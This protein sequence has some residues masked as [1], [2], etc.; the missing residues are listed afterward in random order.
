M[1][2]KKEDKKQ[3][4][5]EDKK[6]EKPKLSKKEIEKKQER[7]ATIVIGI[8]VFII[9]AAIG[10]YAGL[11]MSNHFTYNGL[12]FQKT[13]YGEILLYSV[14]IPVASSSGQIL[15]HTH[16][17][18]RNDPRKLDDIEV[19]IDGKMVF[20]RK[21]YISVEEPIDCEY[22][23]VALGNLALFFHNT[24]AEIIWG[25]FTEEFAE[26]EELPHITCDNASTNTVIL[27]RQAEETSVKEI[28]DDCYEILFNGCEDITKPSEKFVLEIIDQ[29][30]DKVNDLVR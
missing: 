22:K 27:F 3:D 9:F 20:S 14:D 19:D 12:N 17:D 6:Q 5:K 23:P 26:Q 25:S 4:K 30:M 10:T 8:M 1:T 18:F 11:K 2:E 15:G 28:E 24:D 13:K 7:Q 16:V 21:V 29:H